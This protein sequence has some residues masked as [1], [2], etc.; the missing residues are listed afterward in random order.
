MIAVVIATI[1]KCYSTTMNDEG[2]SIG[3][4]GCVYGEFADYLIK[5]SYCCCLRKLLMSCF[6]LF[7][8][9]NDNYSAMGLSL[10]VF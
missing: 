8:Q 6:L 1:M 4:L 3:F 2:H 5:C 7:P 9:L 10:T